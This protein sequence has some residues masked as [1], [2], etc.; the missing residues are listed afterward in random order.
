MKH[1]ELEGIRLLPGA[2]GWWAV[3]GGKVARLPD[4]AVVGGNLTDDAA[5]SLSASGFLQP[6][7]RSTYAVTVLTATACNLGCAYC[8]Q[9]TAPAKPG[10]SAPPRIRTFRLTPELVETTVAFVSGQMLK[11]GHDRTSLLIFGGEPLLNVDGSLLLLTQFS[12]LGL[13]MSEIVTNGVL[14]TTDVANRL[15]AAGLRRVQITFDGSREDHDTARV[16]RNGRGTYDTILKHVAAASE[17]TSLRWNLRVNVSHHNI[18]GLSSLVDDLAQA[19]VPARSSLHLALIDDVGLGYGNS[20]GYRREFAD[21]FVAV[22]DRAIDLGFTVPLSSPLSQ[23]P[24]CAVVGGSGGA[25]I[26]ADGQ[27]YSCWENAGREEWSVGDVASGYGPD[28]ASRWVACDFDS[29]PHGDASE[30]RQFFERVDAAA[31]D[32]MYVR[33]RLSRTVGKP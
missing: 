23:C 4:R 28:V 30:T 19:V 29:A 8:F 21:E 33:D 31:L 12:R 14:L 7:V 6:A 32:A 10:S 3:A 17:A 26:N 2:V 1:V 25:V 15:E 22:N 20:V 9:N 18:G 16:T 27:L 11:H 5:E 24:Y 13:A